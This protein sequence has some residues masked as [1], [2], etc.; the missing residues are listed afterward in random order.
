MKYSYFVTAVLSSCPLQL[1][2]NL[3]CET[4]IFTCLTPVSSVSRGTTADITAASRLAGSTIVTR[5]TITRSGWSCNVQ[6]NYK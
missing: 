2:S 6:E 4:Q 5:V 3:I 1:S